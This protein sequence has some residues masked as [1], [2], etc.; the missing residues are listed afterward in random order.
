[1]PQK[2]PSIQSLFR[3]KRDEMIVSHV[4]THR[5]TLSCV[6]SRLFFPPNL[7]PKPDERKKHVS[8]TIKR[9]VRSGTLQAHNFPGRI[10]Y[11]TLPGDLDPTGVD[12]D[13][14]AL[15]FSTMQKKDR[16]HD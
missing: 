4:K 3:T 12:Y 7:Y 14:A 15:W 5:L 6:V 10:R 9:L 2:R 8:S 13:L 16:F 1:M 11:Y